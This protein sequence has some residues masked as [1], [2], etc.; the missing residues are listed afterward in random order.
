VDS[1]PRLILD[2]HDQPDPAAEGQ[3]APVA[4]APVA[5]APDAAPV[6]EA[7]DGNQDAA[8]QL[9]EP[10]AEPNVDIAAA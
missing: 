8:E 9:E 10:S 1:R 6:A 4:E 3:P 5:D 7:Q 2:V